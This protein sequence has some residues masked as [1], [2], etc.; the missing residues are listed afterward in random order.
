MKGLNRAGNADSI[1]IGFHSWVFI[2]SEESSMRIASHA[3]RMMMKPCIKKLG[4]SDFST[5]SALP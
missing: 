5:A 4:A 1:V 3:R 2:Q